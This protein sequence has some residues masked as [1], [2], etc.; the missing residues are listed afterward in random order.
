MLKCFLNNW[1]STSSPHFAS[2][3]SNPNKHLK[4]KPL[5]SR[6]SFKVSTRLL[7]VLGS[8]ENLNS[9]KLSLKCLTWSIAL[10]QLDCVPYL[11]EPHLLLRQ[12]PI[13]VRA[14]PRSFKWAP[15][16][17]Q[18]LLVKHFPGFTQTTSVI[19]SRYVQS[20]CQ[21]NSRRSRVC[22]DTTLSRAESLYSFNLPVQHPRVSRNPLRPSFTRLCTLVSPSHGLIGRAG[23]TLN[24]LVPR[25]HTPLHNH[26]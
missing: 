18:V 20:A 17:P 10:L 8:F 16:L 24:K 2:L 12:P 19:D 22:F 5:C 25:C 11:L 14:N 21:T 1:K 9:R 26:T 3:P 7:V 15:R 23:I 4:T 6:Y 13:F